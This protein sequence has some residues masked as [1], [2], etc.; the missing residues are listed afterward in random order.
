MKTA[1]KITA[2]AALLIGVGFIN[3][4]NYQDMLPPCTTEDSNNCYWDAS[5]HGNGVGYDFYVI[6]DVLR[7]DQYTYTK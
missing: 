2:I 5:E 6:N 3:T 1:L 7:Y 4:A